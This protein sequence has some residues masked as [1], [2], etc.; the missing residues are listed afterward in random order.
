MLE[1]EFVVVVMMVVEARL[2]T[3]E[4]DE[5]EDE[6]AARLLEVLDRA[7]EFDDAAGKTRNW[8]EFMFDSEGVTGAGLKR[9]RADLLCAINVLKLSVRMSVNFG[10]NLF[11]NRKELV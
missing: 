1:E 7:D 10:D 9:S 3:R 8:R 6:E 5:A 11:K 2:A 4:V